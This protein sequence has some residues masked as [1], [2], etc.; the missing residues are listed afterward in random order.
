MISKSPRRKYSFEQKKVPK[1]AI[2]ILERVILSLENTLPDIYWRM[3]NLEDQ[4][5]LGLDIKCELVNRASGETIFIF[6]LQNKGSREEQL[7]FALR[8]RLG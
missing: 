3:Q 2:N 8:R 4:D 1:K 7:L 6:L 5:D